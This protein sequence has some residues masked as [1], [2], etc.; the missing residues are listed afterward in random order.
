MNT[1]FI[2]VAVANYLN[3]RQN[4]IVP[5]IHWGLF[6]YELDLFVLTPN[7]YGWEVEIKVSKS[8]LIKDKE[9]WKWK[10]YFNNGKIKRLYF[11]IP[12]HLLE[13]KEHIP[14]V[15]GILTVDENGRVRKEREAKNLSKYEFTQN[16]R[17]TAMRLCCM[18]I[19]GLK[20]R[21]NQ[22][23]GNN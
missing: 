15:A 21:L 3:I 8:D 6:T 22:N 18:R 1:E 7:N 17:M 16:E 12:Y 23:I 2:E 14:E 9:K 10:N 19:W 11:A 13:H 5:N 4:L 20:K